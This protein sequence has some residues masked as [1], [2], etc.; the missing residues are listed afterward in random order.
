MYNECNRWCPLVYAVRIQ[1][2]FDFTY[3]LV[4]F[5][6]IMRTKISLRQHRCR[7]TAGAAADHWCCQPYA[8]DVPNKRIIPWDLWP[9]FHLFSIQIVNKKKMRMRSLFSPS[10]EL[11]SKIWWTRTWK[12]VI[13]LDMDVEHASISPI[14]FCFCFVRYSLPFYTLLAYSQLRIASRAHTHTYTVH[15]L[16]FTTNA[17]RFQ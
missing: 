3:H 2:P 13:Y 8:T 16:L 17:I 12:P 1:R 9:F 14:S 4:D 6:K 7:V 5:S 11:L 10:S 15:G